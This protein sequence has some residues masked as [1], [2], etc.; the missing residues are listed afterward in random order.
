MDAIEQ[1]KSL[2]IAEPWMYDPVIIESMS[3]KGNSPLDEKISKLPQNA[4]N[5]ILA[6]LDE[7]LE[8][9]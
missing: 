3:K 7:R 8:T 4:R 5:D 1:L 6:M 2:G 9:L